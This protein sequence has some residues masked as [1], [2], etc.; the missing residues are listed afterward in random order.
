MTETPKFPPIGIDIDGTI[1][2]YPDF[3]SRLSHVW[4]GDVYVITYRYNKECSIETCK[5]HNIRY[6]DVVLAKSRN[7]KCRIVK[8]LGIIAFYD[9]M[10]EAMLECNKNVACFLVRDT[11]NFDYE[12]KQF[13]FSELTGKPNF[14]WFEQGVIGRMID[15]LSKDDAL[16]YQH[17]CIMLV[18][19]L[20][21]ITGL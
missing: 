2:A 8:E 21:R 4:P 15:K 18:K 9:D 1:T 14:S 6:T 19:L 3:F 11:H 7:D 10:P 17:D 12:H 20:R 5:E 13:L 16:K